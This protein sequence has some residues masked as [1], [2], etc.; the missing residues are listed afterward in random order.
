MIILVLR[1]IA[2]CKQVSYCINCLQNV[3]IFNPQ[4]SYYK[5]QIG[6]KSD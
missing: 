2:V 6:A 3:E 4:N 1:N 5:M